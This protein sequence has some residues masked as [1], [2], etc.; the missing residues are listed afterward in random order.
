M[1]FNDGR[2]HR[3]NINDEVNV[4]FKAEFKP[5]IHIAEGGDVYLDQIERIEGFKLDDSIDPDCGHITVISIGGHWYLFFDARYERAWAEEL[6]VASEQFLAAAEHA[7]SRKHWRAFVDN[8]FSAAELAAKAILVLMP[9]RGGRPPS[10]HRGVKTRFN[11]IAKMGKVD[12]HHRDV[13]NKLA[14]ARILARYP[15]RELVFGEGTAD[16]YFEA[17][18]ELLE[19][20]KAWYAK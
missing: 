12:P 17:V 2:P 3:V 10:S 14:Q 8:A 9:M 6:I 16:E 1:F 11:E 19:K 18:R 5:G 13:F 20:A 7:R 4:T 15:K